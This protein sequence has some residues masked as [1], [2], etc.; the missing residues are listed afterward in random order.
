MLE[1]EP[2]V[3]DDAEGADTERLRGPAHGEDVAD[4]V[5]ALED[6]HEIER[7]LLDDGVEARDALLRDL[8][9]ERAHEL[10][11]GAFLAVE[12]EGIVEVGKP[13]GRPGCILDVADVLFHAPAA[14]KLVP[15][16]G[17]EAC[18]GRLGVA[19]VRGAPTFRGADSLGALNPESPVR[20]P[21]DRGRRLAV[22]ARRRTGRDEESASRVYGKGRRGGREEVDAATGGREG[23]HRSTRAAKASQH[24]SPCPGVSRTGPATGSVANWSGAEFHLIDS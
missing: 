24:P 21:R 9:L 7:P 20:A 12:A 10:L 19:R 14:V 6:R 2:R 8:G 4:V 23:C 22:V 18:V 11:R 1:R 3:G 13:R 15:R 16:A 17:D 5:D